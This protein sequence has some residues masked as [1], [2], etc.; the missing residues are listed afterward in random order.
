VSVTEVTVIGATLLFVIVTVRTEIP[1][2]S[3]AFGA[4][5]FAMLGALA[6]TVSVAVFDAG[7]VA[8]WLLETPEAVFGLAPIA[9]PRTTTVTVHESDAGIVRPE[10]ASAVWPAVKLLPAAPAHV[11]PAAAE[12]SMTM[13][14]SVSVKAPAVSAKAFE[15][16][17]VKVIVLVPPSGTAAGEKPLAIVGDPETASVAEAAAPAGACALVAVLVVLVTDA[18]VVTD[19]VMVQLPPGGITPVE[20]PTLVP[21]LTPPVS[22]ALPPALHATLPAAAFESPAGY[23]SLIATLVRLAGFVPGFATTI[24]S[25]ADPPEGTVPGAKPFVTVGAAKTLSVAEAAAPEPAL[26]VE[27]APV[28]LTYAPAAVA[29]TFTVTVQLPE[30]GIVAPASATLAAPFAA[31]TVPPA[32]VVVPLA[33]AVFTRPAG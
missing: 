18:V 11:P 17:M 10:N 7:P 25:V 12:A 14:E 8:A 2:G 26:P 4:N 21:P 31:V 30:A 22:V 20:K 16:V 9:V 23:A 3:I 33:E 32:H 5:A 24:V 28:E 13:P 6:V 15:F 1:P 27:I 29:V 19:C